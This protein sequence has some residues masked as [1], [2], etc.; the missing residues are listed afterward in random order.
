MTSAPAITAIET[1]D[2]FTW[3]WTFSNPWQW[4]IQQSLDDGATWI[5]L[6]EIGGAERGYQPS[7]GGTFRICGVNEDYLPITAPSNVLVLVF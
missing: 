6:D 1:G 7:T 4:Q 3:D 2:G 5:V